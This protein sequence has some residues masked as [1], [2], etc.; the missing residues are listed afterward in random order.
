MANGPYEFI[1]TFKTDPFEEQRIAADRQRRMAELLAQQ[2][3]QYGQYQTPRGP[4]GEVKYPVSQGLAQLAT[5][6]GG[7]F[8]RGRAEREER[9]LREGETAARGEANKLL[10]DVISGGY[11]LPPADQTLSDTA[12]PGEMPSAQDMSILQRLQAGIPGLSEAAQS[13]LS[14]VA[15]QLGLSEAMAAEERAREREDYRFKQETDA[16]FR[17]A[18]ETFR[19]LRQDELPPGVRSGQ[20]NMTTGKVEY[21]YTPASMF[22]GGSDGGGPAR[23]Q[24]SDILPDGTNISVFTDGTTQVRSPSGEVLSGAAAAQAVRDAQQY[25]VGLTGQGAGARGAGGVAARQSEKAF[26]YLNNVNSTMYNLVE[27]KRLIGE[28]ANTGRLQ[29][30]LPDWNASTIELRNTAALLGLDVVGATTF[31]ALSKDELQFALGAALPTNLDG[32]DLVNWIDQKIAAQQ[33]LAQYL[34]SAAIHLSVPGNTIGTFLQSLNPQAPQATG[35][36]LDAM[37]D[38][39]LLYALG[40]Q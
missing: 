29:E 3:E 40:G 2:S 23:V 1:S 12:L 6:L 7:A 14:P 15:Q 9:E 34:N 36:P 24:S 27:A 5:A 38:E 26:E 22:G 16:E 10:S 4:L 37:S 33:K 13:Y 28:G 25:G 18:P 21:D 19:Q 20:I 11:E 39:D 17:E 35:A 32:P 8:K 31:G 30:L